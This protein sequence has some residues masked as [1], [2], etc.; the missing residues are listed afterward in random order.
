MKRFKEILCVV[1][2]GQDSRSLVDRAVTLAG[3]NQAGLTV[4]NV[5]DDIT[6]DIQMP[7]GGLMFEDMRIELVSSRA[8]QLEEL[9][10]THKENIDIQ[11]KVLSGV[12][13]LE[14]IREVIR[15]KYDLVIKNTEKHNWLHHLFGSNDMHLLR[16]NPCP[17]WLIKHGSHNSFRCIVAAI[18]VED[19]WPPDKLII[20]Q[21]LNR[22]ILELAI[23]LALS[24][25]AELH[26]VH[27][28][29]TFGEEIMR[30]AMIYKPKEE[31]NAYVEK[32]RQ[33]REQDVNDLVK[34]VI[35]NQDNGAM[36]YLKPQT[37]LVKGRAREI[38]PELSKQVDADL[39]VMGTVARTG[40]PGFIIGNT[41]ETILNEIDCSVLAIKPQ[42]FVTPVT[43]EE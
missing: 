9:V 38:I 18:D 6:V 2:T 29:E 22:Q 42:G 4:I 14:I 11:L 13:F 36:D 8:K 17:V 1:D 40:I 31:I 43:L 37:H 10:S 7:E 25:F 20:R 26:I 30:R 3:N 28:W 41:A 15:N 39:L 24:E 21:E 27:A 16:M 19:A 34:V 5:I 12:P 23:S 32:V 33:Q 35:G